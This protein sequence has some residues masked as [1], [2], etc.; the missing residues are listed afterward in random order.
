MAYHT[1]RRAL[2]LDALNDRIVPSASFVESGTELTVRGDHSANVVTITDNGTG[3]AGNI[4]VQ[5]DDQ[6]LFTSTG[7]ITSITVITGSGGDV[8]E[9][10]LTGDLSVNRDVTVRLGNGN[11]SF[12]AD[13]TGNLVAG[14]NLELHGLGGNGWDTLRLTGTG[15]D[16][17]DGSKL[18]VD[19]L[20]GNGR[21]TVNVD[22]TGVVIGNFDLEV[23]GGN[24]KDTVNANVTADTGSTGTVTAHVFGGNGKDSLSLFVTKTTDT[25]TVTVDA[26]I[27]GGHGKD[28]FFNSDNVIVVDAP[29]S[30]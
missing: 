9:Y 6:P 23:H 5:L 13:L 24:G 3:D 11:D 28:E 21:D 25:D 2:Q 27:D 30:H 8:V 14:G 7:A 17:A 16:V 15:G 26:T 10:D 22:Y 20:G 29:K 19:F 18:T 12:V 4:T 1:R